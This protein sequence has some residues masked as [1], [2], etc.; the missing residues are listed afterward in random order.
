M[1]KT[2]YTPLLEDGP[3]PQV[4]DE[5]VEEQTSQVPQAVQLPKYAKDEFL[6]KL[7]NKTKLALANAEAYASQMSYQLLTDPYQNLDNLRRDVLTIMTAVEEHADK[8]WRAL[9]WT[10]QVS[11]TSKL[12]LCKEMDKI[13]Q[14]R[15]ND[16]KL[17]GNS[18][19]T[20][21]VNDHWRKL[22]D[23]LVFNLAK[24]MGFPLRNS[25]PAY[26][27]SGKYDPAYGVTLITN[28]NHYGI[29]VWWS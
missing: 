28:K 25:S 15:D 14:E 13:L 22:V 19:F 26:F 7:K 17:K 18:F 10:V 12:V 11:K 23:D 24:V 1:E 4:A 8:G 21:R 2:L 27:G 29:Y 6:D 9:E 16:P 3:P 20:K 5:Q